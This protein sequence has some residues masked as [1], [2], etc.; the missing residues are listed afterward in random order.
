MSLTIVEYRTIYQKA[1]DDVRAYLVSC[2]YEFKIDRRQSLAAHSEVEG[3]LSKGGKEYRSLGLASGTKRMDSLILAEVDCVKNCLIQFG[4]SFNFQE[5]VLPKQELSIQ[6]AEETEK[7]AEITYESILEC[8]TVKDVFSLLSLHRIEY[9]ALSEYQDGLVA[10]GQRLSVIKAAEFL[11]PK[12][13]AR[14]K[15]ER[16]EKVEVSQK[17]NL[18]EQDEIAYALT[19]KGITPSNYS[20]KIGSIFKENYPTFE[21]FCSH[22][23]DGDYRHFCGNN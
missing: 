21:L 22:I 10:N 7:S 14:R 1:L 9:K 23:T 13:K 3:S 2:G 17:R 19:Q 4:V 6:G 18:T 16:E 11:R 12:R 5:Y 20:E 15:Y 8:R